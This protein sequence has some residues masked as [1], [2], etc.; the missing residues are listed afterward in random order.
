[1][2]KP[3]FINDQQYVIQVGTPSGAGRMIH[4]GFA[5]E[6]D[7]F[8]SSIASGVPLRRL[9]E[10]E[11]SAFDKEK[12]LV[13]LSLDD[14]SIQAEA[15]TPYSSHKVAP[16]D[17]VSEE[18][19]KPEDSVNQ[20]MEATLDSAMKEMG[21]QIPTLAELNKFSLDKLNALAVRYAISEAGSRQDIIK[22]LKARLSL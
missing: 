4:P 3:V 13:S 21:T 20:T 8:F 6:G 11:V 17:R 7:Y 14:K 10:N 12:I 2:S 5:V 1:M 16:E 9:S 19:K 22:Q 18:A 15:V